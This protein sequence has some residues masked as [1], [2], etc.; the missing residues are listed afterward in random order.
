MAA[1]L[2][3]LPAFIVALPYIFQLATQIMG[4]VTRFVAWAK[5]IDAKKWIS[6][7]EDTM[8]LLEKAKTPDEKRDAARRAGD[9]L[10]SLG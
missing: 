8:D 2:A 5:S 7:L 4:L 3:A 10:R 9:I 6:E 1:F